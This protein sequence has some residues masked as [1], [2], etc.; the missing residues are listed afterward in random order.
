VELISGLKKNHNWDLKRWVDVREKNI[1]D[2]CTKDWEKDKQKQEDNSTCPDL[3][4]WIEIIFK[5]N[6]KIDGIKN[7]VATLAIKVVTKYA[8]LIE[9]C[10]RFDP[11]YLKKVIEVHDSIEKVLFE[12][13][14]FFYD[15]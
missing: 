3:H 12:K 10:D 8:L 13:L 9:S 11:E 5:E 7:H 15:A 4:K 1:I 14:V 6:C 2:R